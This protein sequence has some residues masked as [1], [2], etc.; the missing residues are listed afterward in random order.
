MIGI[1]IVATSPL[2]SDQ[3]QESITRVQESDIDDFKS[4]KV[5]G[6]FLGLSKMKNQQKPMDL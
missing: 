5:P 2:K 4:F 3:I 1:E 6:A